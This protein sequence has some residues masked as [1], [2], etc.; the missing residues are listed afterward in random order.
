MDDIT[1]LISNVGFPIAC[2]IVLFKQNN[3]FSE[4]LNKITCTLTNLNNQINDMRK[5]SAKIS[6]RL[7]EIEHTITK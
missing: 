1:Q 6:D 7:T 4:I 5:E 3:Q 2:C